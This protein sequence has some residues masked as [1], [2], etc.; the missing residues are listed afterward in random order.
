MCILAITGRTPSSVTVYVLFICSAPWYLGADP[1]RLWIAS[2]LA[3][4]PGLTVLV[5]CFLH[6]FVMR[7]QPKSDP[8]LSAETVNPGLLA[9]ETTLFQHVIESPPLGGFF[10]LAVTPAL[11]PLPK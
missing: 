6:G 5:R 1:L 4:L 8:Y 9:F 7:L 11:V 10:A 2:Y 3:L